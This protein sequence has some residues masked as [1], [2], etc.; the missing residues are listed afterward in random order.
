MPVI[1]HCPPGTYC[2]SETYLYGVIVITHFRLFGAVQLIEVEAA[3]GLK[4][5]YWPAPPTPQFVTARATRKMLPSYSWSG[6]QVSLQVFEYIDN[7]LGPR[8]SNAL[9]LRPVRGTSLEKINKHIQRKPAGGTIAF[10]TI[11]EL[12]RELERNNRRI[13]ELASKHER[14]GILDEYELSDEL[15]A[16]QLEWLLK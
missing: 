16:K 1:V 13:R 8:P 14:E 15:D 6:L 11:N 4:D 9:P 5:K 7:S 3:G 2:R 12:N 10:S